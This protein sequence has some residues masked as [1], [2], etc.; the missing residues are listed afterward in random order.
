MKQYKMVKFFGKCIDASGLITFPNFNTFLFIEK[1]KV[2]R[3][4]KGAVR[5]L[6]SSQDDE[7]RYVYFTGV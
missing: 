1:K 5:E 3:K 6:S 2:L 7:E 4:L